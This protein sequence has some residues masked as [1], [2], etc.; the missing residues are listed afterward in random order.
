MRD[1]LAG[2]A[3][4]A[5]RPV[6]GQPVD[7]IDGVE[8]VTG[9]A[10]FTGDLVLPGML[11]GRV[12]R[13][14]YPHARIEAIDTA[15]AER[16]PGVVAVLTGRDLRDLDPYYG[17]CLRDR[18]IVALDRVR[19]VGEPVAAVA[20]VDRWTADAALALIRVDYRELPAAA[21]V[22][23][24]LAPDAPVLHETLRGAGGYHEL[25]RLSARPSANICHHEHLEAG[26]VARAFAES[27]LVVE[28]VFEFPMVAHC[29]LEPHTVVARVEPGRV[30]VWASCAHP[31]IV[32]AEL[33]QLFGLPLAAVEVIVPYVGGAYGSKSYTKIEPL[34]VALAR[35]TG[36]RPVRV[37]QS[38]AESM[39]TVRRHSARCRI[40]TGV[41]RDGTLLAREAEIWLDTGA[42][43]DNGPRVAK[44]A[45]TRLHGPYR[46]AHFRID[47]LAVYTNTAPAG[48]FRS[49]GGPQA[50]WALE[51]HMDTLA[52]RLGMDPLEF[53]LK[54]LLGRGETL[55]PGATP[56]DADLPGDL[57]AL[58]AA[59]GWSPPAAAP[60]RGV[61]LAVGVTD[62]EAAPVSTAL[63]RLLADGSAVVLAG[64]TEV[65]QGVRTVLAQIVAEELGLPLARVVVRGT[66]TGVTPF[67]RSTGASR[68]TTVMGSAVKRAA[69]D[70]RH[71]LAQVGAELFGVPAAEVVVRDGEVAGG[72]RRLPYG[73]A[74]RLYFGLPGGELIGR[75]QVR[76]GDGMPARAPVFWETGMGAAE[77]AVDEETGE[78]RLLHYVS[79]AE[80]GRA[81]NPRECEGQDEGAAMMGIGHTFFEAL[82]YDGGQ[83]VNATPID[84]RLPTFADL[85]PA[86]GT[87]LVEHG[88]GPG[89]YGAR[90][91]GEAGIVSVAPAVASALARATGVRMRELPLTPERVWRA[92]RERSGR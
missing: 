75:G 20:A 16:L 55:L 14:P 1:S 26:D 4:A 72:G 3:P 43:A 9:R 19:Y 22:E 62:S 45:A 85:P 69:E 52:E 65:G 6:V 17:H 11:E 5:R 21:T 2:A 83:P 90:G 38:L 34:V 84:Y 81:I 54:N 42:Y 67:D 13:S 58:A 57:R 40:K 37:E 33:A 86:F 51:S 74:I 76:A 44:R 25:R 35:K 47:A 59:I 27:D 92:L 73:E 48:S 82:R 39:L 29:A 80:A 70:L 68:S 31:F 77:I 10:R 7:R 28:D 64:S 60:R 91:M 79:L 50:I 18:P 41:R 12:L 46:I 53:R 78:V 63:V 30:T 56:V 89:P 66:D 36:G 15:A 32:Q 49:I 88:D 23:A 8:K 71:Q 24:A 61:G 87:L